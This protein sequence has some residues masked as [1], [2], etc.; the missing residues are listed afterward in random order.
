MNNQKNFFLI[1]LPGITFL[2]F[3]EIIVRTSPQL[4]FFFSSPTK[5]IETFAIEISTQQYWQNFAYSSFS[6]VLGLIL[7]TTLG[8]VIGILLWL[9]PWLEKLSRPYISAFGAVPIFAIAPMLIIWF[10]IGIYSK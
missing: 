7:G 8:T 9:K 3:W 6:T 2:I 4:T 1:A 10:G 5:I